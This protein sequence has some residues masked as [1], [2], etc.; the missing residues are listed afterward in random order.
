MQNAPI[1][2]FL[3]HPVLRALRQAAPPPSITGIELGE[4]PKKT[5][6]FYVP[7]VHC[8]TKPWSKGK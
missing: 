7:F 5:G 3:P 4:L 2:V 8:A 1:P 6:P